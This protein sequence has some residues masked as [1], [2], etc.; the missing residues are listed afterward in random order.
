[1]NPLWIVNFQSIE[2]KDTKDK[3]KLY[4]AQMETNLLFMLTLLPL[5][6]EKESIILN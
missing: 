1:M 4:Y 5:F 2:S 3:V 6:V